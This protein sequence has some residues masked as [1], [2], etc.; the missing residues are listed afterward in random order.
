[1]NKKEQPMKT[2]ALIVPL[3]VCCFSHTFPIQILH[4]IAEGNTQMIT[5]NN[6]VPDVDPIQAALTVKNMDLL[7]EALKNG[8]VNEKT[9]TY[10]QKASVGSFSFEKGTALIY[11]IHVDWYEGVLELLRAGAK[12]NVSLDAKTTGFSFGNVCPVSKV[13]G[14]TPM[15][16]AVMHG[17][18]DIVKIMI[19]AG[20]DVRGT[21]NLTFPNSCRLAAGGKSAMWHLRENASESVKAILK[22]GKK[23]SWAANGLPAEGQRPQ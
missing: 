21:M 23:A 19:A 10:Y 2:A 17:N 3:F 13:E 12:P 16:I 9:K 22:E 4:G 15:Y 1:L 18:E 11:A 20:A 6:S 5:A 14:V 7:K 8:K